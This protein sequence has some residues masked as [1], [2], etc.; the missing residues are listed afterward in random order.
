MNNDFAEKWAREAEFA[1]PHSGEMLTYLR[2][3]LD[4][5]N[6]P[7]IRRCAR[8]LIKQIEEDAERS[9]D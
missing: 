1:R 8:S 5:P 6:H 2:G 7:G 4:D 3:L 9:L